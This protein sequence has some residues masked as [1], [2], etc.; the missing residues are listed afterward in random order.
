MKDAQRISS[1]TGIPTLSRPSESLRGP[2]KRRGIDSSDMVDEA[3][4]KLETIANAVQCFVLALPAYLKFRNQYLGFDAREPGQLMSL[5]LMHCSIHNIY[6]MTQLAKL[7][8]YRYDVFGGQTRL[9][10]PTKYSSHIWADGKQ[11]QPRLNA[12]MNR[13]DT[14]SLATRQY[15]EA[16]DNI[17]TIVNRSCEDHIR[18]VNPFLSYTIWL[19]STV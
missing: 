16:A 5:R 12:T 11:Y 10:R 2:A 17:V 6:V 14:D 19:G 7:M 15:F 8:I 18:Y 4:Q 1:P 3:H 9:S 13:N